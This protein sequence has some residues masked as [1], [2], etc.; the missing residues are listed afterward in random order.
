M[1]KEE[2]LLRKQKQEKERIQKLRRKK[3]EKFFWLSFSALIVLGAISGLTWLI[4][5]QAP[6]LESE[7][8]ARNGIHWHP[9]L[10]IK[11]LGQKME[12]PVNIGLGITE[13]PIHTH[14]DTGI[15][16][17]EFSGF[18]RKDDIRLGE[19]FKVWGKTFHKDCI[20]DKC[21]GPEGQL[22]M[23][24]NGESNSE[25]EDYIMR[26]KDKIEIIFE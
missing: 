24:V 20:F 11:I 8:I 3:I 9:E 16:H 10:S 7:I 13:R 21:S 17:L 4:K 22:K 1:S 15:I 26:D 6:R 2:Y 12:I 25:F 14:E 18:V 19:F 23:L 5:N